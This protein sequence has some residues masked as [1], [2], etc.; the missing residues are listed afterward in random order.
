MN[1]LKHSL[2]IL[3]LVLLLLPF[4]QDIF[5]PFK[6]E[7]L[8]GFFILNEKPDLKK[9]TWRG[10]FEGSFQDHYSKGTEDHI[11]L[12]NSL[13][14]LHNQYDFSLF[15]ISHAQGFIKGKT[16][17]LFEED[18]INEYTGKYFIGK[19]TIERKFKKLKNIQELLKAQ[20]IDLIPVIEPGKASYFPEFIPD[21]YNPEKR[22]L[23]NHDY[24]L[25][26]FKDLQIDYLDLNQYF[27]QLKKSTPYPLFPKYGMH[28]SIYGVA[29]ATDT[30]IKFIAKDHP[31]AIPSMQIGEIEISDSLRYT[32]ND[33]GNMLNLI[34]PLP[35]VHA[36][37]PQL[38]FE[39]D[40][41]KKKLSALVIADSYYLNIVNGIAD[42]IFGKQ[43]YW[44]YNSKVYP[45]IIDND[46]PVY[47]DK[48]DLKKKL[49]EFD[50]ILLMTSEINMHCSYWN[51]IDEVFQA[52][53]PEY[54]ESHVY[55]KE[56]LIRNQREWFRFMVSKARKQEVTLEEMIR[57]DAEYSF[58]NDY[59][60]IQDKNFEDTITHI[61]I[62]IK[63][64]P[65]WLKTVN[66]KAKAM[67]IPL[68]EMID[69]DAR[70]QY[71]H[72]KK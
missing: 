37:Y 6:E 49:S 35:K 72:Q 55:E 63:N 43:E 56:N 69:R 42:K 17:F 15:G 10:W 52:F 57:I 58:F 14:R 21:H 71:W 30:L 39:N 59:N 47:I 61:A 33:I 27:L 22:T 31:G 24:F 68:G 70:Y 41:Q 5:Q 25:E 13:F 65:E 19:N 20:N 44:Y 8:N 11:G 48:S 3:F 26:L 60:S 54:K 45:A 62:D 34:F 16:G 40:P 36:A 23:S 46:N 64:N 66:E 12:R 18:Y 29:L 51:F 38:H 32:D 4:F 7:K 53:H 50:V 1:F 9:F 2:F 28:W 67:N